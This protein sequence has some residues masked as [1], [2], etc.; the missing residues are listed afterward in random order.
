MSLELSGLMGSS[1]PQQGTIDWIKLGKV[2][3]TA[4]VSILSRL[5]AA[6]VDPFTISVAQAVASQ[7]ILSTEGKARI[8]ECLSSLRSLTSLNGVLW[9]GFGRQH[10]VYILADTSHGFSTIALCG[11]PSEVWPIETV[12]AIMDELPGVYQ[13]PSELRPSLLQWSA[14]VSNCTGVISKTNFG[15][16]AEH[17]MSLDGTDPIVDTDQWG[18]NPVNE[19]RPRKRHSGLPSDI[20][21]AL[22]AIAE[23]SSGKL[24]LIELC[25][26]ATCGLLAASAYWFL[27]LDV[28]IRKGPD[29]VYRSVLENRPVRLLV[30]YVDG[31]NKAESPEI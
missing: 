27:G 28:E 30:R 25:G 26:G 29:L 4:T 8:S 21:S 13:A 31:D 15:L 11:A 5:S 1:F 2:G 18:R 12:V 20:A 16:V 19:L 10:V 24:T 3:V 6:H 22:R 7:F 17:F 23:L 9:F 14:L